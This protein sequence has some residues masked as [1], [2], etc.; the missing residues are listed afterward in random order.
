MRDKIIVSPCVA[1]RCGG[2]QAYRVVEF[3]FSIG[4]T[5]LLYGWRLF[6]C[7]QKNILKIAVF[8]EQSNVIYNKQ[9]YYDFR[10][11]GLIRCNPTN[12]SSLKNIRVIPWRYE[13]YFSA[14][15]WQGTYISS[16]LPFTIFL[17]NRTD[18]FQ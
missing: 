18:L 7:K 14:P 10:L 3:V 5:F 1:Q 13:Q 2:A 15:R 11:F 9:I 4:N 6:P 16:L 12:A 8:D 17:R